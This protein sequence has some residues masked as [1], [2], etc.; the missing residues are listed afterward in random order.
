MLQTTANAEDEIDLEAGRTLWKFY[1][2]CHNSDGL[3]QE[4]SDA[5]KVAGDPAWYTERQLRMFRTKV[6]GS[7]PEDQPGLQM[8]VYS[9]PLID[10]AAIRNMVAF[11]ASLPAEPEKPARNRMRNRPTNRPL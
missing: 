10:D 1:A 8:F 5:P 2:F 6:R 9:Y 11:I 3:G 7:H 4:R